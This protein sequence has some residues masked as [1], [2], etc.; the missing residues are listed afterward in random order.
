MSFSYFSY[1]LNNL[2]L[3]VFALAFVAFPVCKMLGR[4]IGSLVRGER[5]E[6]GDFSA[7]M[8]FILLIVL[9]AILANILI[10]G[11]GLNL[12]TERADDALTMEGTIETIESGTIWANPR[13]SANGEMS[14]G[15]TLTVDGVECFS[16][17]LG[18]LEVGDQVTVTY[19]PNS[20]Y[21]LSIVEK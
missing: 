3:P 19:M 4:I 2:M 16:M 18:T 1:L 14:N 17:A 8:M 12:I 15:Y 11:G 10:S 6:F 9:F 13:Y 21:V 7:V 20:G 5:V